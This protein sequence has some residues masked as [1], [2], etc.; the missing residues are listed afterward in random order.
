[1]KKFYT[2][3]KYKRANDIRISHALKRIKRHNFI[4]KVKNSRLNNQPKSKRGPSSHAENFRRQGYTVIAAPTNFSFRSNPETIIK[5]INKITNCHEKKHP[6]FIDMKNIAIIN[7]DAI[8]ILLSIIVKFIDEGISYNGNFPQNSV[9]RKVLIFSGFLRALES[10]ILKRDNYVFGQTNGIYTNAQ[11]MV[12]SALGA[13]IIKQ[14]SKTVWGE[15]RRCQGV[16]RAFVELMQNTFDHADTENAGGKHWLLSVNHMEKDG[17]VGFSFI[18]FGVGVFKSL[19]NKPSGHK[20]AG[21]LN[22]LKSIWATDKQH[23]ILEKILIGE[24][25]RTATGE[26]HRGKGLPGIKEAMDRNKFSN[27]Y[28]ITNNAF[29]FVSEGVYKELKVNFEGTFIYL[30]LNRSNVSISGTNKS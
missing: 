1:M 15:E 22:K 16:Q 9:A 13:E 24:M 2:S 14:A 19:S 30:E 27:L 20:F 25:H 28:V 26:A 3:W 11:K 21:V 29:S 10:R 12:N 7:D 5:F 17:K 8:V 6:V 23:T 18:D 4:N